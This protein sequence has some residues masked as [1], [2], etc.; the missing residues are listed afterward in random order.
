VTEKKWEGTTFGNSLM[1]KWLIKLL[2]GIDI[3]IIYFF[4][5]VFVIPPCLLRPGFK[6]I[7]HY[8]RE[9][10]NLSPVKA[11]IK[12]YQNHYMFG[13]VVIDRFAMYA[14]KRFHMDI[15][16]YDH[17][18]SLAKQQDG[19]ILLSSHI[20]N[21][22]IAGYTLVAEDKP[23]NTLVFFGEKQSIMDYRN[24]MFADTNIRM[25]P[26]KEDMSHL[27]LIDHAL[28]Q[29]E[30][31]S[32]PADRILGSKKSLKVTLLGADAQIPMGPFAV[33]TMRGLNVLAV[34]VM[35][36]S[37]KGYKIYVKPIPYDKEASRKQQISQLAD[38]YIAEVERMLKLYPTQ[39]YNFFEFWKA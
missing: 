23:F 16:G 8:F 10:W 22:E 37:V 35:K 25:I 14:G 27:F 39:W 2:R 9:R 31:V 38:G 19:F 12:T 6:P 15:E 1:H 17:F 21:Y 29:G 20:G 28:Q 24:Q 11:F 34:N 13:Q 5:Y 30:T 36:T 3:R 4:T 32:M 18:L 33:A 7:Y 26:V